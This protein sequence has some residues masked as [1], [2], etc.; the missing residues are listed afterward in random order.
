MTYTIAAKPVRSYGVTFRSQL[1]YLWA[2]YFNYLGV[3]WK[4]EPNTFTLPVVGIYTPDFLL[5]D[6]N[7]WVEVKPENFNALSP[8][9]R[10]VGQKIARLC[11]HTKQDCHLFLGP[12]NGSPNPFFRW[13]GDGRDFNG[14]VA[15]VEFGGY[16]EMNHRSVVRKGGVFW[17]DMGTGMTEESNFCY[18]VSKRDTYFYRTEGT[19]GPREKHISYEKWVGLTPRL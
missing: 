2:S 5:T 15:G 13:T 17:L 19:V 7:S 16:A 11:E 8:S 18:T 4:Y 12:P 10:V 6:I 9:N 1:E 3:G 14:G